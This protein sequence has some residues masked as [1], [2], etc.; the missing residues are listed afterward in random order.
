MFLTADQLATLTG[1]KRASHQIAALRAMGLPYWV[2]AAGK[3]IVTVAAVEGRSIANE[4]AKVDS[5]QPN[6]LK[7]A[8]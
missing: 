1:R 5:W 6:I 4:P 8:A 7:R 3:P 2:N